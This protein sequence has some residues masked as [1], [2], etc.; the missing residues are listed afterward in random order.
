MVKSVA[1][2]FGID[3]HDAEAVLAACAGSV[4]GKTASEALSIIPIFGWA[5]KAAVAAGTTKAIG[6]A[7]INHYRDISPLRN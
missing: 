3:D 7:V 2:T 4:V 6:E 1:S 5:I